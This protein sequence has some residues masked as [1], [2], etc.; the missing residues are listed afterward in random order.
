MVKTRSLVQTGASSGQVL[1]LSV[2]PD[3]VLRLPAF[4]KR[5]VNVY[6]DA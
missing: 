3:E 5:S 1:E 4:G 2:T 6:V